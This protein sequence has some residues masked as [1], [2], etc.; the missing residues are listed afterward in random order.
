MAAPSWT[1]LVT[2]VSTAAT[3]IAAAV[4]G[5]AAWLAYRRSMAQDVP[6]IEANVRW[7]G[8]GKEERNSYLYVH[9]TIRNQLPERIVVS[10]AEIL[11]PARASIADSTFPDNNGNLVPTESNKR[12]IALN[13]ELMPVGE[14]SPYLIPNSLKV[15][16]L[17]TAQIL[18][19]VTPPVSWS[20]GKFSMRLRYSKISLR[21]RDKRKTIKRRIPAIK[22]SQTEATAISAS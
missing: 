19:Y 12:L 14:L 18:L 13:K 22:R 16:R 9:L 1:D 15:P 5:A 17:D 3:A 2:A 21:T 4:A 11:R 8:V 7:S 20:G 6:I 10:S